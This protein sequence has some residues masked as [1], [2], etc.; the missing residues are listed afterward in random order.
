MFRKISSVGCRAS[1][2]AHAAQRGSFGPRAAVIVISLLAL[3]GC[4]AAATS[5]E[6][7]TPP[8]VAVATATPDLSARMEDIVGWWKVSTSMD[9]IV[10]IEADGTWSTFGVNPGYVSA[11]AAGPAL[12]GSWRPS[13][14]RWERRYTYGPAD[15]SCVGQYDIQVLSKDS[16]QAT[17]I[18]SPCDD[19][20][21]PVIW[22]RATQF[23][24]LLCTWVAE[25]EEDALLALRSD[26]TYAAWRGGSPATG[27]VVWGDVVWDQPTG[28]IQLKDRAA[29]P[30][31]PSKVGQYKVTIGADGKATFEC[32]EDLCEQRRQAMTGWGPFHRS[33]DY[34]G[35]AGRYVGKDQPQNELLL[36]ACG[37]QRLR[38]LP[39]EGQDLLREGTYALEGTEIQFVDARGD[40]RCGKEAGTYRF[41][42]DGDTLKLEVVADACQ[43]RKDTMAA[44]ATWTR[45]GSQ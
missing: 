17:L 2:A 44:C 6:A 19:Y 28:Q 4:G 18:E 24:P 38:Q 11:P 13:E 40:A 8:L 5:V 33:G 31:G 39:D 43:A 12:R 36:T 10:H 42:L 1:R 20:A 41:S 16:V 14:G 15:P 23:A 22:T 26:L 7:P 9:A 30:C 34:A 3:V 21:K 37:T 35:I 25:G 32:I 45:V 27:Q 29:S